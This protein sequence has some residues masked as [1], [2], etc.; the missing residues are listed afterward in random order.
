VYV[1]SPGTTTDKVSY[2]VPAAT[3]GTEN[4]Q[5]V[6]LNA[7]G[8][9]NIYVVGDCKITVTDSLDNLIYTLDNIKDL[10]GEFAASS[11]SSLVGFIQ[12][13]TG[14]VARTLQSKE[15]DIVSV[16]DFGA[17]GDGTTD[18]TAAIQSAIDTGYSLYIPSG[19][20]KISATLNLTTTSNHG[21]KIYGAGP[22]NINGGANSNKTILKP[23]AAVTKLFVIDGTSF[24]N[25]V[26]HFEFSDF[27]VDMTNMTDATT[28]A[29]FNQ[30]HAWGG[31]YKN[32]TVVND[33][34]NKRGLLFNAG[35]YTT[36]VEG[37]QYNRIE[38]TGISDGDQVTT[39]SFYN[40]GAESY[41]FNY[42]SSMSLFG[43]AVQG[44]TDKFTLFHVTGLTISGVD[45]EG[46]GTYLVFGANCNSIFA[47]GNQL[48]GFAGTLQTGTCYGPYIITDTPY[49]TSTKFYISRGTL[50]LWND[51]VNNGET[52]FYSGASNAT[53]YVSVG[54]TTTDL[55]IVVSG[56]T[57]DPIVGAVAGD[58]AI[59][60]GG[61]AKLWL[62]GGG[63]TP[64]AHISSVGL[65]LVAP[66]LY[67]IAGATYSASIAIDSTIAAHFA[68]NANTTGAF[69]IQSP[70]GG[71]TGQ[72]LSI[73]VRNYSGGALG[74]ITWGALYKLGTWTSPANNY[75][76]SIT[77]LYDGYNWVEIAR[78]PIDVPV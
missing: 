4:T 57:N 54:R 70:S 39:I 38:A 12:S 26:Q 6:V 65:T 50:R 58:S 31:K 22:I 49:D 56:A 51:G 68:I 69:T 67:R 7:R 23:T 1:Y 10:A 35:A 24:A 5:P 48:T 40:V 76:I 20:Y 29:A 34:T 63:G 78:T 42:A 25:Y 27:S 32:I 61:T 16:K 73:R 74:T 21:Q 52:H 53:Y 45:I 18:D 17:V 13:G 60:V 66:L 9:A 44:T 14:A 71:T 59:G 2:T 3:G 11:G 33:G 28:T 36:I 15:R 37:G 75:S 72:E 46:T 62:Y 8:E 47:S 64:V 43:G 55:N 41:I 77:F 30:I 19:T